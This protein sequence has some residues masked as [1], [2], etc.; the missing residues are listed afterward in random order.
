[1]IAWIEY[2]KVE[3]A[4][5]HL[6]AVVWVM[7]FGCWRLVPSFGCWRLGEITVKLLVK[8]LRKLLRK[9]IPE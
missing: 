4:A 1:M 3:V 9:F 7:A 2:L 5:G 6:G 8:K